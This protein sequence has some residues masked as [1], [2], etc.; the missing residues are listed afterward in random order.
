MQKFPPLIKHH[1]VFV[2]VLVLQYTFIFWVLTPRLDGVVFL[3]ALISVLMLSLRTRFSLSP[4][5]QFIDLSLLLVIGHTDSTALYFI[6]PLLFYSAANGYVLYALLPYGYLL[7]L[8][9]MQPFGNYF[10]MGLIAGMI[11]YFWKLDARYHQK[12]R[13]ESRKKIYEL[14]SYQE[15]LLEANVHVEKM[16]RLT[17]RQAIAQRLHDDLGHELTAALLSL[18]AYHKTQDKDHLKARNHLLQAE[19]K[20]DSSMMRLKETVSTIEPMI[21]SY[22]DDYKT[23]LEG[24]IYPVKYSI[25]GD[26]SVIDTSH[27]A[28]IQSITKEALTNI[29]KHAKPKHIM[30]KLDSSPYSISLSVINDGVMSVVQQEGHG[31]YFMR[32]RV[33]A[34]GGTFSHTLSN[35]F[36]LLITLPLRRG[37]ADEDYAR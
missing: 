33:E 30:V 22:I 11:V 2:T 37:H 25:D 27:W 34:V 13:D 21:K 14:L 36:K 26:V 8:K 16:A 20:L 15:Q 17:E 28:L 32:K 4:K 12:Q 7:I 1:H 35:T 18:K 29:A 3:Y 9:Q 6:L 24:F 23:L 10:T 19:S 31:L 5:T